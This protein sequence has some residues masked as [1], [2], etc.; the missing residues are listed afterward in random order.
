MIDE[1]AKTLLA[2]RRHGSRMTFA[3]AKPE[4]RSTIPTAARASGM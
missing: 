4:P 1:S 2:R 3:K